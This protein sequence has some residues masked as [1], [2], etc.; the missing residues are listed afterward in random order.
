MQNLNRFQK[1]SG[2]L[3]SVHRKI[4]V[5]TGKLIQ[6]SKDRILPLPPLFS[7]YVYSY[8]QKVSPR[9]YTSTPQ[10]NPNDQVS[11]FWPP[12]NFSISLWGTDHKF[13]PNI[14]W[15]EIFLLN[16]HSLKVFPFPR[17]K[18]KKIYFWDL[19]QSELS[20]GF[21]KN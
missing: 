4:F 13:Q 11:V 8:L 19:N 10:K 18:S 20:D 9:W 1:I 15:L 14:H 7:V 6:H 16:I 12:V 17:Q 2:H 3:A 5:V 21:Y